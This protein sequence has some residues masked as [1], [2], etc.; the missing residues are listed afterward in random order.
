[1]VLIKRLRSNYNFSLY[2]RC[3][4]MQIHVILWQPTKFSLC[5][6]HLKKLVMC[7]V[8]HS[9]ENLREYSRPR[10][11]TRA[12]RLVCDC[13]NTRSSPLSQ[14][15]SISIF[16]TIRRALCLVLGTCVAYTICLKLKKYIYI[17]LRYCSRN[18]IVSVVRPISAILVS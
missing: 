2:V 10:D 4:L 8:Y 6:K 16:K 12:F 9:R 18:P 15:Q 7:N 11:Y 17:H 5:K 13:L 1:M 14:I 3:L